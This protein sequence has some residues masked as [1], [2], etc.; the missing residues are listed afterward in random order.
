M[1]A[2]LAGRTTGA[3]ERPAFG[4]SPIATPHAHGS[5]FALVI[6][7]THKS[8]K[9]RSAVVETTSGARRFSASWSV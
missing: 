7:A 6:I 5:L 4:R 8:P 2:I 1:H 3:A 9:S